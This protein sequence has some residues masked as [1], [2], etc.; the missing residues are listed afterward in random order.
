MNFRRKHLTLKHRTY[1]LFLRPTAIIAACAIVLQLNIVTA[2]GVVC[3]L[4]AE[5][6]ATSLCAK[7]SPHCNGQCF[8]KKQLK[9]AAEESTRSNPMSRTERNASSVAPVLFHPIDSEPSIRLDST[10][11]IS[12]LQIA[13]LA[14]GARHAVFNPP[15]LA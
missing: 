14:E 3:S 6:I 2:I 7:Q 8:L 4:N 10:L 15:R 5:G 13:P 9:S 1:N 11:L 12:T